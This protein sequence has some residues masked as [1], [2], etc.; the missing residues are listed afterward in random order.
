[1]REYKMGEVKDLEWLWLQVKTDFFFLG[2]RNLYFGPF[3][4]HL[5]PRRRSVFFGGSDRLFVSSIAPIIFQCSQSSNL[6]N[7][8]FELKIEAK[9]YVSSLRFFSTAKRCTASERF[10]ESF[11]GSWYSLCSF[12]NQIKCVCTF[13]E[14]LL[15]W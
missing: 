2:F 1:M 4:P 15:S 8:H 6:C 3:P 5:H 13:G 11:L 10:C 12:T 9:P 14:G 7:I